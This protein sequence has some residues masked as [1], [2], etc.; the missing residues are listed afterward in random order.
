MTTARAVTVAPSMRPLLLA[1]LLAV[2][3]LLGGR[4]LDR[5]APRDGTV[6]R[7]IDG[8]T[9]HVRVHGRDETVRLL[10]IDTPE[11][12]RPEVPVECGAQQAADAMERLA[13]GKRVT[14]VRDPTQDRRDQY[15]RLLAYVQHGGADLGEAL[16]REGWADVYVYDG[17]PVRRIGAYRRAFAAARSGRR[18]VQALCGGDYHSAS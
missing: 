17:R 5:P 9:V 14:L 1:I 15:G 16:I 13:E 6:T 10:G 7:V 3:A 8:D 18:G 4:A 2:A 11:L 12:H